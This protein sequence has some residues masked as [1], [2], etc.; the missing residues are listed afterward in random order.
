[1]HSSRALCVDFMEAEICL[2]LFE[3]DHNALCTEENPIYE[4][5]SSKRICD[6]K[7]SIKAI[8]LSQ[9]ARGRCDFH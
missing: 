3:R 6:L 2:K 7:S 8:T 1:M 9:T 4:N 5:I